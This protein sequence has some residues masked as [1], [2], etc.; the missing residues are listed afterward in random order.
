MRFQIS[1][2]TPWKGQRGFF[3]V[4]GVFLQYFMSKMFEIKHD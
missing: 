1:E 2:V 3:R 4:S